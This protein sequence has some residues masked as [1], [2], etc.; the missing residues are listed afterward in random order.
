VPPPSAPLSVTA[1]AG[2]G[3]ARVAWSA[4][5][6]GAPITG[7]G[8]TS[9]P[10]GRTCSTIGAMSCIV[11][12]LVNGTPYTFSVRA[13]NSVGTGPASSASN[14]VTP[15]PVPGRP[16]AV[17]GS[18]GDTTV[19]VTWTAPADP[20]SSSIS[21]YTATS[22]PG[23]K[24][25]STAGTIGCTVTQL[26]NG[27]AY[28]FTVIATNSLGMGLPSVASSAVTPRTRPDAPVSVVALA[29]NGSALVSWG[30][31]PFSGGSVVTGYDVVSTPDGRTCHSPG[32]LSCTVSGLTNRA[33]YTFKVTATNVAGTS[34][35]SSA[36]LGAMPLAGATYVTITP[37][38]LV[39]SRSSWHL[40][41]S[42]SLSHKVPVSFQVTG[43]STDPKLN[44]PTGAVAVTGNLTAVNEGSKGYFSLTPS[45]PVGTPSTSTLNFPAGDI[46]AN[47][48]TVPL[49]AGGKLWITYVGAAG[50]YADVVFDVTG[51][52]VG[53]TSGA[54]YLP[55]TPSRILD[56]R[57]ALKLGMSTSLTSLT[58]ASFQV[59]GRSANPKLNVPSNAL[60]VVGNL[61]AVNEA[62]KG[63][64]SLTPAKP[65]GTPSTSTVNFPAGDI[66][67]N[68]V[69]VPLGVGGKLWI[70][71]VGTPGTKADAV[72]DVTGY[73]VPN[74]S[75][76]TY[77]ALTPSRLVDSRLGAHI[78]LSAPLVSQVPVRF[79][80]TG[81]SVDVA[82]NVPADAVGITGNLTAVDEGSKGYFALTPAN[83]GGVPTTSTLNFPMGDIR[84]NAVTIP[85]GTG[86]G[87]WVT[88]VGTKG[89]HADVVVDVSGYFTMN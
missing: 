25:C 69:T 74:T 40:G 64:L 50:K 72:F 3:A 66:R 83:P 39:D 42:A 17:S 67:A 87:L 45:K 71:F 29:S 78:G 54:T 1:T 2:N 8:V 21:G 41:L 28:T 23:G 65:A 84:A 81:R 44:I 56:S 13:T 75:G 19:A 88:F 49:G 89:T 11:D 31:P 34:G 12:G 27:V 15:L 68:G 77:V 38:R 79:A 33:T 47:A 9:D 22:S 70:T 55:L 48:V 59:T 5:A 53:N 46:R 76:A 35:P 18:A 52:F 32:A 60:A 26:T 24:T 14:S 73:F 80:V 57:S 7:Y 20:G 63:Y 62:S 82:L 61:T 30:S 43:R 6:S 4:P 36:S 51:Y 58:P 85:L 37:N 86:G 16:T 10:G